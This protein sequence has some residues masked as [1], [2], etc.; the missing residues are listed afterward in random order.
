MLDEARQVFAWG[1]SILN[2]LHPRT[3]KEI[4]DCSKQAK[5]EKRTDQDK[6]AQILSIIDQNLSIDSSLRALIKC[7]LDFRRKK[8]PTLIEVY[9]KLQSI[10]ETL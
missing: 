1:M 3:F 10:A 9:Q 2:T 5:F 7:C 8:R 6:Y 4:E